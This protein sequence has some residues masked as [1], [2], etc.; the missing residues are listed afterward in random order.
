[1]QDLGRHGGNILG[2]GGDKYVAVV[3]S[4]DDSDLFSMWWWPLLQQVSLL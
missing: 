1:M 3:N 2:M 4:S